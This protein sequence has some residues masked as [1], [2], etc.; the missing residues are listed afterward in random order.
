MS[1]T[2]EVRAGLAAAHRAGRM[3]ASQ[4]VDCK[5]AWITFWEAVRVVE[6]SA[7]LDR[8]AGDLAEWHY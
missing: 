8:P 5:R 6:V 7:E 1:P 2:A 4:L 3:S